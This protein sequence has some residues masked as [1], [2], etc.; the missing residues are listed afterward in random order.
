MILFSFL[1]LPTTIIVYLIPLYYSIIQLTR[2]PAKSPK[3]MGVYSESLPFVFSSIYLPLFSYMV[4]ESFVYFLL[5]LYGFFSSTL[6]F[7]SWSSRIFPRKVF[8]DRPIVPTD[9]SD[10]KEFL[11]KQIKLAPVWW[12][13]RLGILSA[14]VMEDLIPN[15]DLLQDQYFNQELQSHY[16]NH[17]FLMTYNL[18]S[19]SIP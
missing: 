6:I 15:V 8:W 12:I 7:N 13:L 10:F 4:S 5:V 16:R 19:A 14:I 9:Y 3:T 2:N 1:R 18:K 17:E 11:S